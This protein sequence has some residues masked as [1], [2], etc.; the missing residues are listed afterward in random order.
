MI[1]YTKTKHE[2][3]KT[4]EDA[5]SHTPK[6]RGKTQDEQQPMTKLDEIIAED[7]RLIRDNCN[8]YYGGL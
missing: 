5:I 1:T 7:V 2:T 3:M 6:I 4:K 8:Y